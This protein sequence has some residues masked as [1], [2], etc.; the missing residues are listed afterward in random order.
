MEANLLHLRRRLSPVLGA[1]HRYP[2]PRYATSV[3]IPATWYLHLPPQAGSLH[4]SV[5]QHVDFITLAKTLPLA[6]VRV[7]PTRPFA[8]P[9][10]PSSTS[11]IGSAVSV[12]PSRHDMPLRW[13]PGVRGLRS[14]WARERRRRLLKQDCSISKRR[15]QM[16]VVGG[17]TPS[18]HDSHHRGLAVNARGSHHRG[19]AANGIRVRY[20]RP[21][22]WLSL[23]SQVRTRTRIRRGVD[24]ALVSRV[25]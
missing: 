3:P 12:H 21:L 14:G 11:A 13:G 9:L 4:Q 2:G 10:L 6:L 1:A 23:K 18:G 25:R 7:H 22:G 20:T 8:R 5:P 16:V 24:G 15:I 19:A 17:L